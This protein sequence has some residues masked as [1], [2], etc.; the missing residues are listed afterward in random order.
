[1]YNIF[2]SGAANPV[3]RVIAF[4]IVKIVE[5]DTS[6]AAFKY[7]VPDFPIPLNAPERYVDLIKGA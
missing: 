6:L 3:R 1:M 2:Y 7:R 4:K 5:R